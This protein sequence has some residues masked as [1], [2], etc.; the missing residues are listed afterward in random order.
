M[1]SGI[2]PPR[3]YR[4]LYGINTSLFPSLLVYY[5]TRYAVRTYGRYGT[6]V[7]PNF[8]AVTVIYVT[9]LLHH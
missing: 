6:T 2:I 8:T 9:Y 1:S 7:V 4:E 5:R 3:Y